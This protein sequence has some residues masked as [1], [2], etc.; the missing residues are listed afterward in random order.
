MKLGKFLFVFI[1]MLGTTLVSNTYAFSDVNNK[2]WAYDKIMF[3]NSKGIVSGFE[4]GTFR[5]DTT[6]TREQFATI[7]VNTL[8]L[9]KSKWDEY[10]QFEDVEENRWSKESIEIASR[11]ID[12]FEVDGKEYF[13]PSEPIKR[14]DV[15]YAISWLL[16]LSG[17]YSV[18]DKFSDK[19]FISVYRSNGIANVVTHEI[20]SG[21]LNGTFN[22]LGS[23][24]R[25]ELAAVICNIMPNINSIR[26]VELKNG[27]FVKLFIV[28]DNGKKMARVFSKDEKLLDSLDVEYDWYG[29]RFELEVQ[30]FNN[31]GNPDFVL[32]GFS[33]KDNPISTMYTI[34][35]N[36]DLK[37]LFKSENSDL[38]LLKKIDDKMYITYD[39]YA[40]Y[41]FYSYDENN[42]FYELGASYIDNIINGIDEKDTK[43]DYKV[44]GT[45]KPLESSEFYED[46]LSEDGD[47][48]YVGTTARYI[49]TST[50]DKEARDYSAAN[51]ED[52]SKD[53]CW[54]EGVKGD[55]IG[56]KIEVMAIEECEKLL[57]YDSDILEEIGKETI[58]WLLGKHYGDTSESNDI[59]LDKITNYYQALTSIQIVNG[60]AKNNTLWKN[61]NR[62]KK[63]K[64]VIDD[65]EEYILE[66]EDNDK[67]QV[68]N[69]NYENSNI[70]RPITATFEILE[71]YNGD[72]YDDT[73]L[74]TLKLDVT[75]NIDWGGR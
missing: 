6:V 74:T 2:H 24:T 10:A 29:K 17:D 62:V 25:A 54:S 35:E 75:S 48:V 16:G 60:Y 32:S 71:V 7:L 43:E 56:E 19:D 45:L 22:P 15:A 73:M 49:T 34:L 72:K 66:L 13:K 31:D 18:L 26:T 4:D 70:G 14:E 1:V 21:N 68:F 51:L 57:S 33:S 59:D 44:C 20:M 3:L 42:N 58:S 8:D 23:L 61:N 67:L 12:G 50:F 37:L 69:L 30:D 52:I 5:P 39:P 63:L 36:G 53:N 55:G 9:K 28:N 41:N 27:E 40:G 65:K 11:Y 46:D 64:M 38:I 47:A